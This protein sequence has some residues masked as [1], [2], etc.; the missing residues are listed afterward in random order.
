VEDKV[1]EEVYAGVVESPMVL[2]IDTGESI[3]KYQMETDR[4]SGALLC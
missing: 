2:L 4:V 3:V 1:F